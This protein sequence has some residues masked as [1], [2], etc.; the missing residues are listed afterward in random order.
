MRRIMLLAEAI[1]EKQY[2]LWKIWEKVSQYVNS[3]GP[4][5]T[6]DERGS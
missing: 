4:G 2:S 6:E 5:F 3:P 1:S